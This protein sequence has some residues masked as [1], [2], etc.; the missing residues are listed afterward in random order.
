M[1]NRRDLPEC[2]HVVGS[3]VGSEVTVVNAASACYP[4]LLV[5]F[6]RAKCA[7]HE[8]WLSTSNRH[9]V[10]QFY[11]RR[12]DVKRM[13]QRESNVHLQ[14]LTGFSHDNYLMVY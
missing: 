2:R 12:A 11:N 10:C 4:F 6:Q 13:R 5:A 7:T 9:K 3:L 8:H 1:Y 14:R